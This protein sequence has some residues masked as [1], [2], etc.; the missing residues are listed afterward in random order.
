[1][2]FL[3]DENLPL[4]LEAVFLKQGHSMAHVRNINELRGQP[5]EVIFEYA[6]KRKLIIVT[7][8]LNF[9]N[10]MRFE[11]SK[12]V[13]MAVL[14]FPNDISIERLNQETGRLISEINDEQWH[15][16]VLIEPGSIRLRKLNL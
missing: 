1:M 14:R 7:R 12:L 16:I 15:S 5:D 3:I 6:A 8:D 2:H 11:L 10:P 9:A 13:G 4:S